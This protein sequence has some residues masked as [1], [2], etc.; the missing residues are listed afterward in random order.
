MGVCGSRIATKWFVIVTQVSA[1]YH[2]LKGSPLCRS[3]L[4]MAMPEECMPRPVPVTSAFSGTNSRLPHQG[5][6]A[7]QKAMQG[8]WME[9]LPAGL[10]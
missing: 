5:V 1:S 2:G 9:G 8:R 4:A 3:Q 6:T 7:C 10:C